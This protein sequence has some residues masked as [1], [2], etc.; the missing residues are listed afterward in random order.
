MGHGSSV[1][2]QRHY[3]S[4]EICAD[5]Y[6][7]VLGEAPQQALITQS[8]S[9]A[10]SKSK[11]RPT[12]LTPEQLAS[13]NT[14]FRILRMEQ[15][16]QSM[17]RGSKERLHA[18]RDLRNA[19]QRMK[20]ALL[21]KTR[22][23]W[24]TKQAVDD[25]EH[26]LCGKGFAPEPVDITCPPQHPLQ[27]Q[28]MAA[29]TAPAEHTLEGQYRRKNKAIHALIAYCTVEEGHTMR[30]TNVVVPKPTQHA[31]ACDDQA[32][33][34]LDMPSKS[35]LSLLEIAR[36][37]VLVK[38]EKER[39]RRCF[40]CVGK[41]FSLPPG[42]PAVESLTREFYT[43]SDLSKHFRRRHLSY[44]QDNAKVECQVCKFLCNNKM[45]FQNHAMRVHGTKTIECTYGASKQKAGTTYKVSQNLRHRYEQLAQHDS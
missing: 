28:M 15:K 42:D 34:P 36:Q 18:S 23:E 1:P 22:K 41:A 26:Q 17:S 44:L 27:E 29:L 3:L 45:H 21:D 30:R 16:V 43:P 37:S 8:C 33:S 2:F 11:R 32:L 24:T 9:I 19:K 5:T 13:I 20:K 39:P 6:A 7:I 12:K 40:I 10:H 14:D 25:I 38:T 31:A 4:R 35:T